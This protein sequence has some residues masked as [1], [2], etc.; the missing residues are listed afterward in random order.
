MPERRRRSPW[1][2][3]CQCRDREASGHSERRARA[4]RCCRCRGLAVPPRLEI[5]LCQRRAVVHRGART[6]RGTGWRRCRDVAVGT[7]DALVVAIVHQPVA[8]ARELAVEP[9]KLDDDVVLRLIQPVAVERLPCRAELC[10]PTG[11]IR[12]VGAEP[13]GAHV[14]LGHRQRSG[15]A[16][17]R[18]TSRPVVCAWGFRRVRATSTAGTVGTRDTGAGRCGRHGAAGRLGCCQPRSD[19]SCR[20]PLCQGTDVAGV[21]VNHRRRGSA[22]HVVAVALVW[23]GSTH[24]VVAGVQDAVAIGVGLRAGACTGA[25]AGIRRRTRIGVVA[26]RPRRVVAAVS[27]FPDG[28]ARIAGPPC[29]GLPAC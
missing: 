9:M 27:G 29:K 6:R 11:E 10:D 7:A 22:R 13:V 26:C 2:C 21:A 8:D 24:A 3:S 25:G 18:G 14:A 15:A 28:Y 16:R 23:V 20:G 12:A 19:R 5:R 4:P 17:A 1:G